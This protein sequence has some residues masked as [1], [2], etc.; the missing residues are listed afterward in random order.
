MRS[1][2]WNASSH[3]PAA[4]AS[5][6][7]TASCTRRRVI[8]CMKGGLTF[9]ARIIAITSRLT[10]AQFL[11][12]MLL[13]RLLLLLPDALLG[14]QC[15]SLAKLRRVVPAKADGLISESKG[16]RDMVLV[17]AKPIHPKQFEQS[18]KQAPVNMK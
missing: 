1:R 10:Q 15:N 4:R 18:Q 14:N 2:S 3:S 9:N 6:A 17:K 13:L 7:T 16:S 12:L 8:S 11:L 5:T